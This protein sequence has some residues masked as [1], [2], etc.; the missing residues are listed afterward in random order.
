MFFVVDFFTADKA[1]DLG[2]S[3]ASQVF[4]L[5]DPEGYLLHF[6]LTKTLRKG[7]PPPVLSLTPSCK[8]VVSPVNWITYYLSACDLL[9]VAPD[10][11]F[12]ASDR[13][14]DVGSGPFA[15]SAVNNRL[16]GYLV[17]AKLID[18]ETPHSSLVGL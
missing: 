16:R 17:E 8:S 7:P 1:S 14:K 3:L 10:F 15:G 18:G 12:R 6:I 9:N 2:R 4:N 11:F 13:N 5:K